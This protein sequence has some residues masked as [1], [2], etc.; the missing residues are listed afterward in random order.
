[1]D[2]PTEIIVESVRDDEY[3]NR[4]VMPTGG[5]AEIKIGEK[6]AQLHELFQP[7]N[8]VS[9]K[10]DSYT[11]KERKTFTY[12]ADAKLVS[13]EAKAKAPAA[14]SPARK[15]SQPADARQ[16][17]IHNQV[18]FK[19]AGQVFASYVGQGRFDKAGATEMATNIGKIAK[20]I[21]VVMESEI[22]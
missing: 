17:D 3:G 20:E 16:A 11:N 1:M 9:L 12:V 18:A 8:K 2:K 4:W 10:W 21:L 15:A 13:G 14:T 6:R 19:I 5:G 22:E 7:S